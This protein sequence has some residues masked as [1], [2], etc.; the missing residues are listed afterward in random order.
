MAIIAAAAMVKSGM[1]IRLVPHV[2]SPAALPMPKSATTIGR[3]IA[4]SDPKANSRMTTAP[5]NPCFVRELG[6]FGE[7]VA[8]V[9]QLEAINGRGWRQFPDVLSGGLV[10]LDVGA[11]GEVQLG[12]CNGAVA[13]RLVS[14]GF[15]VGAGNSYPTDFG[16][17][18]LEVLGHR[19]ALVRSVNAA[20]RAEDDRRLLTRAFFEVG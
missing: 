18:R 6:P 20:I 4:R 9:L 10:F 2:M 1:V 16:G 14:A 12:I 11:L 5:I 17:Y 19:L 7:H 3:N 15:G 13:A 8:A